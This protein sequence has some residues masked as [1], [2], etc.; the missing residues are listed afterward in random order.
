M[1]GLIAQ[2]EKG[3][4]EVMYVCIAAE[5]E[6]QRS[7]GIPPKHPPI[8]S[9]GAEGARRPNPS[10]LLCVCSVLG[11]NNDGYG[12]IKVPKGREMWFSFLSPSSASD[13]TWTLPVLKSG[14]DF[15]NL[16]ELWNC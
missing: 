2:R 10:E 6:A 14:I 5:L 1:Y 7:S 8:S 3:V 11:P 12:F 15:E 16:G 13:Q 9:A 4:R